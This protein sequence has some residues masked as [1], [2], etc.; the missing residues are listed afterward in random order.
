MLKKIFWIG[1]SL[2]ILALAAGSIFA[3]WGYL[4]ITRDLPKL[5]TIQ[6]YRPPAVSKVFSNDG[7]LIAEF[8]EQKRYPVK[9][10]EIPKMLIN[11]FLAAEDVNFYSHQGIDFVSILRAF[12]KN[13]QAGSARQGGSTITQQVVK[14]LL[15]TSERKLERKVKEAILS[16]RLEKRFSKD[17]ILQIYLNFLK[18]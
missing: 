12:Y 6:D 7:T 11:A 16:Y 15:L 9:A 3:T 4:R 17:E 10:A 1:F 8:Y 5:S 13:L 18:I 2:F 14:N